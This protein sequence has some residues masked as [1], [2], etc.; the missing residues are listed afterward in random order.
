MGF[1]IE[2]LPPS[3]ESVKLNAQRE[4]LAAARSWIEDKDQEPID[5]SLDTSSLIVVK[6]LCNI[7]FV[8]HFLKHCHTLNALTTRAERHWEFGRSKNLFDIFL[9]YYD[10][11]VRLET[12]NTSRGP[13]LRIAG[14]HMAGS[15]SGE[16]IF[17]LLERGNKFQKRLVRN[18][19]RLSEKD[20]FMSFWKLTQ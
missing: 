8:E 13:K 11:R 15:I 3:L 12:E 5:T 17:H 18:F 2:N 10:S 9:Q 14:L 6:F 19:A 1:S 16:M 20:L 4:L 7:Q